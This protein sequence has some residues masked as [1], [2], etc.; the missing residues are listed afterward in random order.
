MCKKHQNEVF[1][2]KK[3]NDHGPVYLRE[4]TWQSLE[5]F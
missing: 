3:K 5:D 4:R 1:K 2:K